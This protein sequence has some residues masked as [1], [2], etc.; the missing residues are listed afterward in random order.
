[1]PDLSAAN[2]ARLTAAL[3]R[4]YRTE[5][6]VRSI[7]EMVTAGWFVSAHADEVPRVRYDRRKWNRMD[8]A[9]Q[10]EYQKKLDQTKTEYSLRYAA[11]EHRY[12]LVPKIVHDW[13][14]STPTEG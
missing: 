10:Q 12:M 2:A 8:A 13:F 6:G 3:D 7:R 11:S 4:K 5:H 1:M 9:Q 14:A